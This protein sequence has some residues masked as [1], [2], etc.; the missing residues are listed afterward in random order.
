MPIS[1]VI[2]F[3]LPAAKRPLFSRL[4]EQIATHGGVHG[5]YF[6]YILPGF[7]IPVHS[8][9]NHMCWI[10]SESFTSMLGFS[11]HLMLI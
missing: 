9:E 3:L 4:R 11:F 8:L 10:I 6:G 5:Q 1:E 2:R 7:G